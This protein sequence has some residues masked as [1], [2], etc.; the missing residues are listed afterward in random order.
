MSKMSQRPSAR[1]PSAFCRRSS[2]SACSPAAGLSKA[3][4]PSRPERLYPQPGRESAEDRQARRQSERKAAGAP[5]RLQGHQ[6]PG[7]GCRRRRRGLPRRRRGQCLGSL[8]VQYWRHRSGMRSRRSGA[9]V[10]EDRRGG[11]SGDRPAGAAGTYSVPLRI[12]VATTR[13]RSRSFPR[14]T[15]S[16]RRPTASPPVSF[17]SSLTRSRC[18][19]RPCS[20][21]TSIRSAWASRAAP[22]PR[23]SDTSRGTPAEARLRSPLTKLV[24]SG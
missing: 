19:C 8:S 10:A 6:L 2:R 20:L 11:R 5:G 12:T 9:G 4:S 3:S 16:R 1:R 13:T 21:P 15:R 24:Q 23:R 22:P 7:G 17:G 14:L 18:R